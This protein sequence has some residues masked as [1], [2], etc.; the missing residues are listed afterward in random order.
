M[1]VQEHCQVPF[2]L[3]LHFQEGIMRS[4]LLNVVGGLFCAACLFAGPAIAESWQLVDDQI[5]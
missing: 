3:I 1:R 5:F 4:M 2:A